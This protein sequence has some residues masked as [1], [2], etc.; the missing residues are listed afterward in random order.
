MQLNGWR[1]EPNPRP[2]TEHFALYRPINKRPPPLTDP[3]STQFPGT[4]RLCSLSK[5]ISRRPTIAFIRHAISF[6]PELIRVR[7]DNCRPIVHTRDP[8]MTSRWPV[9]PWSHAEA[10]NQG[11]KWRCTIVVQPPTGV[12]HNMAALGEDP[13]TCRQYKQDTGRLTSMS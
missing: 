9:R 3:I 4:I 7:H 11:H 13:E 2:T 10:A 12:I 5:S 8:G 6:V 1:T